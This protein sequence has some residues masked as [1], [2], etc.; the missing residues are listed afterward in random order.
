M[1]DVGLLNNYLVLGG[2]IFA[3]G[4]IGF[5]T[6]RNLIVMFLC[7]E[8]ML[9]G[10][11]LTLTAF[12]VYHGSWGGQVFTLF[13]LALA[14]GEASIAMAL[15]VVLFRRK[16]SLDISLWQDLREPDQPPVDDEFAVEDEPVQPDHWPELTHAGLL[17]G[18]SANEPRPRTIEDAIEEQRQ[19]P[20]EVPHV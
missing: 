1:H 6:R 8:L 7:A 4:L 12:S 18:Q 13:S 17:P 16:E 2:L 3:I 19:Q 20:A 9:Q 15:I 14:G 5:L 11:T 10:V